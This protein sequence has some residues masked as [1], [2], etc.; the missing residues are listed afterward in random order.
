MEKRVFGQK[1]NYIRK[2]KK[3]TSEKLA[4]KCDVNASYIRQ[5]EAGIR[6]PSLK[7]FITLCNSLDISPEY[8]LSHDIK[9]M[10]KPEERYA[11]IVNKLQKLSPDE[12]ETIDCLLEAYITKKESVK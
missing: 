3:I 8:L 4:E 6:V 12:L 9:T 5:L 1:L 10:E 11:H 7:L 2:S